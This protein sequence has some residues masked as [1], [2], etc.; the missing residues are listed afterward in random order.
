MQFSFLTVPPSG[1]LSVH[2][3]T[4]QE[5]PPSAAK[6]AQESIAI[7]S[8][9]FMS[10]LSVRETKLAPTRCF[11]LHE[12]RDGGPLLSLPAKSRISIHC[13]PS[14]PSSCPTACSAE[15]FTAP[16]RKS[17]ATPRHR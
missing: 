10:V 1:V 13:R 7:L 4:L 9:R 11:F 6:P 3:V 16:R 12:R 14:K 5:A 8:I 15:L 17:R 2:S